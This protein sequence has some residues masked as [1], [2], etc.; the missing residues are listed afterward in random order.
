M[1]NW[2]EGSWL[3]KL[4]WFAVEVVVVFIGVY[5]AFQLNQWQ[6][7]R[8]ADERRMQAYTTLHKLFSEYYGEAIRSSSQWID[9]VYVEG[10]LTP[11]EQE[12]QPMPEPIL[13]EGENVITGAWES[14]LETGGLDALDIEF[15]FE[16][17]VYFTTLGTLMDQVEEATALSN[18]YLLPNMEEGKEA[19]YSEETG[20]LKSLYQWYPRKIKTI[21]SR[22]SYAARQTDSLIAY[23]E[24][25]IGRQ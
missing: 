4:G 13:L 14:M 12:K 25:E 23:L 17:E 2:K 15:V 6:A 21:S 8:R 11:Y 18:E 19:F 9:N 10:F 22:V 7:E 24:G 20:E 5:A 3:R 16:V 1:L